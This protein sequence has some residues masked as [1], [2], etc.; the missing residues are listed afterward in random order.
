MCEFYCIMTNNNN[1]FSFIKNSNKLFLDKKYK[2][3]CVQI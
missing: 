1:H 3:L 2:I